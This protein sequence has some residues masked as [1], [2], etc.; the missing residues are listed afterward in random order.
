MKSINIISAA[1]LAWALTSY[2]SQG[3]VEKTQPLQIINN[4]ETETVIDKESIADNFSR[5]RKPCPP[6]GPGRK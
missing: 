2:T 1:F 5:P 3:K 4:S 6:S